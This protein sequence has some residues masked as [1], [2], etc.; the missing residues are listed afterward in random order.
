MIVG[1]DEVGRGSWAGPLCVAAVAWP[2]NARVK[3]LADSKQVPK[4]KRP[5]MAASIRRKAASIGIGWVAATEIDRIG[6][7]PALKL[8]AERALAQINVEFDSIIIDGIIKMVA[9]PRAKTQVKADTT[10]PAVMA[11]SVIAKVARDTYMRCLHPLP[12]YTKYNF[13]THV[14][15]GTPAHRK[16]LAQFGPCDLHRLSYTPLKALVM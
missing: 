16:L 12:L 13:A 10:V 3:G 5:A 15:Y 8:A 1:I 14:G 6:M 4:E 7:G 2:L 9:D 11:A